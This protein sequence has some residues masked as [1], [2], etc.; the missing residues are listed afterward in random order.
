MAGYKGRGGRDLV[1][2]LIIFGFGAVPMTKVDYKDLVLKELNYD[3]Y[4]QIDALLSLQ[5][6]ISDPPHHDEMF[7]IIIHQTAELWFKEIL[8]ETETL[9][10]S[11]REGVV[12]KSLKTLKR[13][14]AVMNL[15]VQQIRLLATLTP[16]EFS[17]FRNYLRPASGFQSAQYRIMEF[18][19][20][21]RDPF[22]LQFFK[23]LPRVAERLQAIQSLPSVYDECLR[24]LHNDGHKVPVDILKRDFTSTRV[25]SPAVVQVIK[26]VYENPK[27]HYHWVLLFEAMIDLDEA[28]TLWRKTHAVMVA[29]TIGAKSGTAVARVS[30]SSRHART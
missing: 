30:N 20:G 2:R 27:E 18:T 4:L 29:R 5:R 3:S 17:G 25:P 15:Q 26:D 19:Y 7:F 28:M 23:R 24:C 9:I 1:S 14:Q 16:V 12:S 13:I 6:Q 21:I 11:F 22:F 8:H 10:N